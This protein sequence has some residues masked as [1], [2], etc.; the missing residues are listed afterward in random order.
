[1]DL[2]KIKALIDFA[3]EA[4]LSYLEFEEQGCTLRLARDAGK[5][6]PIP[7]ATI[8]AERDSAAS[9]AEAAAPPDGTTAPEASAAPDNVVTAPM[10]GLLYLSPSPDEA[11]FVQV[12]DAVCKGQKLCLLEAMK[13]FHAVVAARD[14]VVDAILA[15]EG[16]EVDAGQPLFRID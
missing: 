2:Q 16:Q 14:G 6:A 5:V 12:G 9:V 7:A 1:M 4:R 13:V 11:P 15:G 10:Y 8:V 3:A